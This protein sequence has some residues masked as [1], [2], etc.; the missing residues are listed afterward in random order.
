MRIE[1]IREERVQGGCRVAA[2]AIWEDRDAATQTL[3][4]QTIE[5]FAQDLE[6]NP[7]AF[8]LALLP[9]AQWFGERRIGVE[10]SICCRLRDGLGAAMDLFALWYDRCRVLRIEPTQGFAPTVPSLE[11]RAASFFSGGID[12]LSLLRCNRLDYP[13]SHPGFIRDCIL[14]FGVNS[15]DA[16]AAGPKPDRLAAFESHARRMGAFV[17]QAGAT[18]IPIHT[19]IRTFYPDFATWTDVGVGAGTLS[20]ALCLSRR[21][22]RV[23]LASGGVGMSHPPHGS[24]PWLDHYYSTEAVAVHPAQTAL[25]RF[26]KTRIVAEWEEALSVVR[27]CLYLS[28]PE[29]GRINCGKCEKCIRTMLALV[30]LGKLARAPTFPFDDVTPSMLERLRIENRLGVLFY[31]Q[32]AEALVAA[33]RSD[34]AAPLRRKIDAYHRH[35]RRRRVLS[36]VRSVMGF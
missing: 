23:A 33:G 18:L 6:P 26:E 27:S 31:T 29:A 7:N 1:R 16:D 34:L 12:A 22:D 3:T 20:T 2:D 10:G 9:L 19:N 13:S 21:I 15:Y 5:P 35:K 17:E 30:A 11:P 4:I 25:S 36:F 8:L 14:L 32:C 28:I 24:H